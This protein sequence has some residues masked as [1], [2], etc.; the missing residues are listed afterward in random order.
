MTHSN[1]I[2]WVKGNMLTCQMVVCRKLGK[3]KVDIVSQVFCN[4]T[5]TVRTQFCGCQ[6]KWKFTIR[7]ED[8]P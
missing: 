7:I 8:G 3:A 4:D 6:R 5:W 2:K 1:F